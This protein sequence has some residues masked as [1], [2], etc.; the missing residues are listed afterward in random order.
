MKDWMRL[1]PEQELA[2]YNSAGFLTAATMGSR[3]ALI[4]VDVTYGFTGDKGLTL[5]DAIKQYS[6]ACGPAAWEAMP[7]LTALIGLFRNLDLPVVF[8]RSDSAAAPF[9]GKATKSKGLTPRDVHFDSFPPEIEPRTDEW[10]LEKSRASCFFQT[11][12]ATYLTRHRVDTLVMCGVSTSGCVRASVVDG[13][14]HGYTTFVVDDCTFDRS[15]FAHCANLFDMQAKY[16]T[17]LSLDELE[18]A[19]AAA[20]F[21]QTSPGAAQP[22]RRADTAAQ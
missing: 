17:V 11:P 15:H 16:A 6:T 13:F 22:E 3:P 8:T 7:R 5:E 14:S 1:V 4:V 19:M 20:G 18:A 2:T 10:V 9:M 21:G 12:L